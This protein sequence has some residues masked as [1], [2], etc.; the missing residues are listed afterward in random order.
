[1]PSPRATIRAKRGWNDDHFFMLMYGHDWQGAWDR[2]WYRSTRKSEILA[3]M[4]A[5][6]RQHGEQITAEFRADRQCHAGQYPWGW[7]Q[8]T[9]PEPRDES[10]PEWF[11]LWKLNLITQAEARE[12]AEFELNQDPRAGWHGIPAFRRSCGWWYFVSPEPRNESIC[13][14]SQ[15]VRL[16]V[17]TPREQQILDG[18]ER[19]I[20]ESANVL[21]D[22][23]AEECKLLGI[24][25][26]GEPCPA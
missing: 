23:T 24:N 21:R 2:E 20:R 13:E 15:L 18:D 4:F 10:K 7:W 14:L 8:W 26:P 25:P 12:A 3:D 17:L 19:A 22:L 11:Q 5:C 9:S 1:M 6:W 16:K